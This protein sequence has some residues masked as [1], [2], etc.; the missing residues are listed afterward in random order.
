MDTDKDY[1]NNM[2]IPSKI[3]S[4]CVLSAKFVAKMHQNL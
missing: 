3:F 1:E 4:I 2:I